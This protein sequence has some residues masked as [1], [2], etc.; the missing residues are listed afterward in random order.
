MKKLL[1]D[2]LSSYGH[3]IS[4]FWQI[5]EVNRCRFFNGL[6]FHFR[7]NSLALVS[8]F[9]WVFEKLI[10]YYFIHVTGMTEANNALC[11]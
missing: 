3:A 2:T 11:S 4:S 1:I 5:T 7:Y 10:P 8:Q 9:L 6:V